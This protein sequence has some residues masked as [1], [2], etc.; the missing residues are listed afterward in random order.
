MTLKVTPLVAKPVWIFENIKYSNH[1]LAGG[2]NFTAHVHAEL[3]VT[4]EKGTPKQFR[5][6]ADCDEN[7]SL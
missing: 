3:T 1:R 5:N 6:E 7:H 2:L 4:S